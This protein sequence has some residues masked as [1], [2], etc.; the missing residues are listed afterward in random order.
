[1]DVIIFAAGRGTRLRPLTDHLPKPLI[2]INGL[3]LIEAHLYRLAAAGFS[4]VI[5]NLHHLGDQI[6]ARLGSGERYHLQIIYSDEPEQALETAGGIVHAL[7][8]IQSDRFAAISADVL[9]DYPLANLLFCPRSDALGHLV[10]VDNPPH[11]PHGDF[12]LDQANYLLS[13]QSADIQPGFT[14][15]GLAWFDRTLFDRLTPGKRALRPVLE[16][17]IGH[18]RLSGEL[19]D[20][21]WSD[22]G[23][24]Q[25]LDQARSCEKVAEYIASIKQSIS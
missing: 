13:T 8:L 25:R 5:V 18:K 1:M 16:S 7:D 4:R 9:C 14:F 15:S 2:E 21:L 11:H 10:M 3:C 22:I 19:H 23:T 12:A 24:L 17:T 6:K 20:G